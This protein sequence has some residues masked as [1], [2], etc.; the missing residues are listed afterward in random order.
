MD[1]NCIKLGIFQHHMWNWIIS[2]PSTY[3]ANSEY[4]DLL[5]QTADKL[6]NNCTEWKWNFPL[7]HSTYRKPKL[8]KTELV[9]K[10][11]TIAS[12][13]QQ[14]K[15]LKLDTT[16]NL[17]KMPAATAFP[18]ICEQLDKATHNADDYNIGKPTDL[19]VNIG[20]NN[21]RGPLSSIN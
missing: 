9:R 4:S 19:D 18:K 15:R 6:W 20:Y 11:L 21:V 14:T 13:T 3:A 7:V 5:E 12:H 8:Q 10:S 2:V 1:S 16:F 17:Y